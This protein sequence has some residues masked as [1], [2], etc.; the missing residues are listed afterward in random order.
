MWVT[1][2]CLCTWLVS[3]APERRAGTGTA[4][5]QT[6]SVSEACKVLGPHATSVLALH[7]PACSIILR[8][9]PAHLQQTPGRGRV[10]HRKG[11]G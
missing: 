5:A 1:C 7:T 11:L 4:V 2:I 9:L 10:A 8:G 6:F 3:K